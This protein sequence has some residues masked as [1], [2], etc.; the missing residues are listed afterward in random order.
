MKKLLYETGYL[1]TYMLYELDQTHQVNPMLYRVD[2]NDKAITKEI[3]GNSLEDSIPKAIKALEMCE[4]D[5][6]EAFLIFPAD[7]KESEDTRYSSLV[8]IVVDYDYERSLTI[9]QPYKFINGKL[10]LGSYDVMEST[11]LSK[12]ELRE[13]NWSC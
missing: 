6:K 1:M 9:S 11:H 7:I 8:A 13:L 10:Y 5:S 2:F 4:E 3:R 12:D